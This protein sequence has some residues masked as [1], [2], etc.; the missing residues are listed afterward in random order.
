MATT[1]NGR[2]SRPLEEQPPQQRGRQHGDPKPIIIVLAVLLA[3]VCITT[4]SLGIGATVQL[5]NSPG[6]SLAWEV[7]FPVVTL[8]G[9]VGAIM[10]YRRSRQRGSSPT[11]AFLLGELALCVSTVLLLAAFVAAPN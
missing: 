1:R 9:L 4:L 11:A 10:I 2:R 7:F 5:W 6:S 3:Y 8:G